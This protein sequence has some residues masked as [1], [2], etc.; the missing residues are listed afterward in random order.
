MIYSDTATSLFSKHIDSY[1]FI[2]FYKYLFLYGF[3]FS[4]NVTLSYPF[5]YRPLFDILEE[6]WQAFLPEN[7]FSC[8]KSQNDE[9]RLSTVNKNYEV[10]LFSFNTIYC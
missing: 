10:F 5:F 4:D 7:E 1:I 9:W 2:Y 3:H 6:G 8:L